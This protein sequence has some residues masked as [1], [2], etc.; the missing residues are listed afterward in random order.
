L[1]I[2]IATN[3]RS[4]E[5][6]AHPKLSGD[7]GGQREASEESNEKEACGRADDG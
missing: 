2:Y 7:K 4:R 3:L 5:H 6:R 1:D